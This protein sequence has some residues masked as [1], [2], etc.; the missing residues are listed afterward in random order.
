[1]LDIRTTYTSTVRAGLVAS[2]AASPASSGPAVML[3]CERLNGVRTASTKLTDGH[4]WCYHTQPPW[5]E[6]RL[7]ARNNKSTRKVYIERVRA[8]EG[9]RNWRDRRHFSVASVVLV[10]SPITRA[11]SPMLSMPLK[12]PRLQCE[13]V[14][15]ATRLEHC[16]PNLRRNSLKLS[17]CGVRGQPSWQTAQRREAGEREA[18]V[19]QSTHNPTHSSLVSVVLVRSPVTNVSSPLLPMGLAPRLQ[20]EQAMQGY[21]PHITHCSTVRAGLVA[22]Q[23]ASPASSGPSVSLFPR[24]LKLIS[25]TQ[26]R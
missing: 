5:A 15:N 3:L 18:V 19:R 1:M 7:T 26:L 2:Q 16:Q 12:P 9:A 4:V 21:G 20:C 6:Q 10:R 22:S 17:Q 23:A 8:S 13:Q 11:S 24:R 25:V 14:V